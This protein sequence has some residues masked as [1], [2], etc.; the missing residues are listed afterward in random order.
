MAYQKT[1][2]SEEKKYYDEKEKRIHITK[3]KFKHIHFGS[4]MQF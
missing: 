1:K 3:I 2:R 4:S